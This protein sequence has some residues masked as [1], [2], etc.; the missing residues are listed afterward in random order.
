M[1]KEDKELAIAILIGGKSVRFGFEKSALELFGKPLIL[2]QV[3]MLSLF[4]EDVFLIANSEEQVDKYFRKIKFPKQVRF[5][6]DDYSLFPYPE[7][8]TPILGIYT[9]LN[10][11]EELGF[12]KVFLLAGDMPLIK[13]N[14][15]KA[16][17]EVSKGY[18]CTI[19]RWSNE[20]IE[21]L[22]AIYPVNEALERCSKLI[23]ERNYGLT[24]IIDPEWKIN[25]VSVEE[26]FTPLDE[27][28]LS[29]ININGPIDLQK[30][31]LLYEK[32]SS[33]K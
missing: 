7:L 13:R 28:L 10:K 9:A 23:S 12:Y 5:V 4:D 29:L 15:I 8:R 3:E 11:L 25:Y 18:K 22:F 27:N 17:I 26:F 16:F 24:Q 20:F 30:L 21:P 2:H 1:S 14:V 32:E 33:E 31:I 6:F 19:P